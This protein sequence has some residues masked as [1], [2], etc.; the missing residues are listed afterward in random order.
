MYQ[1][2]DWIKNGVGLML[3]PALALLGMVLAQ[4]DLAPGSAAPSTRDYLICVEAE[5]VG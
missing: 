2:A 4:F 3:S 5:A 1:K